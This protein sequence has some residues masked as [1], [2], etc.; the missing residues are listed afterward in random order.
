[1]N[2]KEKY[3]F[4]QRKINYYETDKMAVVHHSNYA[5]YLEE[6]RIDFMKYYDVPLELF[7]EKGYVIP[8]L[9]LS[10]EFIKSVRFGEAI[11]IIPELYKVT[12]VRFYFRYII[13]DETGNTIMHKAESSHCFLD[14][15][16][17]PVS[18]KKSEPK[19]YEKIVQVSKL[20]EK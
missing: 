4:Y 20:Y 13:Y 12:P 2:N 14:K 3:E 7:E 6:S 19:L 10:E 18:L 11:R 8:V 15:D 1:M 17:K 5:R 9:T 16:Y